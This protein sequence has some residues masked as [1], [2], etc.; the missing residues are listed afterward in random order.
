MCENSNLYAFSEVGMGP[1]PQN[2]S[3]ALIN[4]LEVTGSKAQIWFWMFG[5]LTLFA[6]AY[7]SMMWDKKHHDIESPLLGK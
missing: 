1:P 6:A 2:C 5:T 4:F 7:T 3:V